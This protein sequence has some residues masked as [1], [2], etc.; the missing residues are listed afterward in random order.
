MTR[1]LKPFP[2]THPITINMGFRCAK[3]GKINPRADKTCRN[4]CT[5]CLYSVHVDK[6]RPGDRA[7]TC[8]GLME[9]IRIDYN[10]KKGFQILH[11]CL[12][13]GK[14][15]IN[16][17]ATDDDAETIAKIM[18]RQNIAHEP[19]TNVHKRKKSHARS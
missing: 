18:A 8:M 11:V 13:C 19:E 12:K 16:K 4:H 6:D 14:E 17:A 3:C 2:G 5:G 10:S 9:P 7:S 15:A 1:A